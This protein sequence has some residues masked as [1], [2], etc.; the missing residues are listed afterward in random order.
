M[1]NDSPFNPSGGF[2]KTRKSN[3]N[4]DLSEL[5]YSKLTPQ[6]VPFEEAVLGAAMID[7]DAF[8]GRLRDRTK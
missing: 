2:T 7:K 3:K 4:T 5:L 6:A 8:A 1:S